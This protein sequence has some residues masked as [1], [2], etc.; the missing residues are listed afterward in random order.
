MSVEQKILKRIKKFEAYDYRVG[1]S[2]K[3]EPAVFFKLKN[4]K[5]ISR[6]DIKSYSLNL[7]IDEE[8]TLVVV[9]KKIGDKWYWNPFGW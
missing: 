9:M 8:G 6:L 5:D 3:D 7:T 4:T 1:F 2:K